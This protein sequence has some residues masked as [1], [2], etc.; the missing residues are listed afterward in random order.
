MKDNNGYDG[1]RLI[2]HDMWLLL[3]MEYERQMREHWKKLYPDGFP[4]NKVLIDSN[5]IKG[6][7]MIMSTVDFE[8]SGASFR[9]LWNNSPPEQESG[10]YRV[11]RSALD[12]DEFG[13]KKEE[14][15]KEIL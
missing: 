12:A 5:G 11:F 8:D 2:Y 14:D 4:W 15:E 13:F 10:L 6:K 7:A 3:E 9:E 1:S